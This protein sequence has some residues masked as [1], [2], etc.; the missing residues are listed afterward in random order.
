MFADDVAKWLNTDID[1]D[2]LKALT[3]PNG[4]ETLTEKEYCFLSIGSNLSK[5]LLLDTHE[6]DDA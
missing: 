2:V 1:R 6:A 3:M 5:T 4:G